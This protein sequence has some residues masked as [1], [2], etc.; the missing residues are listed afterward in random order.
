MR[1]TLLLLSVIPVILSGC[2]FSGDGDRFRKKIYGANLAGGHGVPKVSRL[3]HSIQSTLPPPMNLEIKEH[4]HQFEGGGTLRWLE[5]GASGKTTIVLFH[6]ATF[7]AELWQKLGTMRFFA[8]RGFR[9]ISTDLPRHGK[10]TNVHFSK[11]EFLPHLLKVIYSDHPV[12]MGHSFA[13]SYLFPYLTRHPESVGAVILVAPTGILE[14]RSDLHNVTAPSLIIWGE[15]DEMISV[16]QA[17]LLEHLLPNAQL[18]TLKKAR[19]ECYLTAPEEFHTTIYNF[20]RQ[21]L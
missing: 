17:S 3:I 10:S 8:L 15:N 16:Q 5:S 7:R 12:L 4:F 19:H 2:N 14:Y 13:G 9:T 6:G 11:S 1:I 18:H 20:L 21:H